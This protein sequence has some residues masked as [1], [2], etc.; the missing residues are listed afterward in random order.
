MSVGSLEGKKRHKEATEEKNALILAL[1]K[2]MTT[3]LRQQ[4][5][6]GSVE[7]SLSCTNLGS[8]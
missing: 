6:R 7:I 1:E 4:K 5:E 8:L 3:M 2:Q